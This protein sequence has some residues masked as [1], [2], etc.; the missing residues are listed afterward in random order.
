MVR[1]RAVTER[2]VMQRKNAA[3]FGFT[4]LGAAAIGLALSAC[5]PT[6][7]Q[8]NVNQACAS[9]D[10]LSVA[11][12][13]FRNGL[14]SEATA[15]GIRTA[16]DKVNDAYDSLVAEAQDVAVDR[17]NELDASL[18]EFRSA[19]DSVPDDTKIPTAIDSL[20]NEAAGVGTALDSLESE[21]KC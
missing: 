15:D 17:M 5:A 19:V 2:N 12:T 20:R 6:S 8:E 9:A 18:R 3:S 1:T 10:K 16:R 21:L 4:V 14:T 11:L 13:E 7:P